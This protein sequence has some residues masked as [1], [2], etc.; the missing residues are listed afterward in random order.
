MKNN[1]EEK[2]MIKVRKAEERGNF[3]Y[4]WL[5]TYHTFS[6][7]AYY[8]AEH[9]K[10]RDLRVINE[11]RVQPGEG[12]GT[13]PHNDMEIISYVV[14]GALG[15]RDSMG[16]S[17]SIE[18]GDVQVMTAGSGITHS[19]YNH[20]DSQVTHFLQ[21][22]II[23]RNKELEPRYDQRHFSPDDKR[24]LLRLIVSQDGRD[25]SLQINQDVSLY[26]SVLTAGHE[27][28]YSLEAG[29][30]AWLQVIKG[31]V[32]INSAKLKAGDGAA[33][34]DEAQLTISAGEESEILLFDLN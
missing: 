7:A 10:F 29:R 4:G 1:T 3:D 8:D 19:E 11:D 30:H 5:N 23:P 25:G 32:T 12:F 17:Q 16:H 24:D 13:H 34:S 18:P 22:W 28:D 31:S 15:H 21:V 33:V 2:Q 14:E 20:S 27:L 6:F 9:V 26:A